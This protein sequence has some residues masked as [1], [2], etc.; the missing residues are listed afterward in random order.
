MLRTFPNINHNCWSKVNIPFIWV[1]F[2]MQS[3]VITAGRLQL[4]NTNCIRQI[5]S[6]FQHLIGGGIP[7][8]VFFEN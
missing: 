6:A 8:V 4:H 2:H 1:K 5:K 3:G 7:A